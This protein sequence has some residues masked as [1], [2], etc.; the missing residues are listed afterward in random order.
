MIE[1]ERFMPLSEVA[2]V[3]AVSV[4]TVRRL[5]ERGELRASRPSRGCVRVSTSTLKEF[6]ACNTDSSNEE[7]APPGISA[8]RKADAGTYARR[9]AKMS[10]MQR[11][12]LLSMSLNEAARALE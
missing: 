11:D 1:M 9:D 8:I 7:T 3:L 5:I 2:D 10:E 12:G 6:M 4:T